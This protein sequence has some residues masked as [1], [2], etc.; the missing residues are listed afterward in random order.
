MTPKLIDYPEH[1]LLISRTDKR[2]IILAANEAF[3]RVSGFAAQDL[4]GAPHKLVR[5]TDM[6]RG[7][8]WHIWDR[9]KND[10]SASGYVKNKTA[11]GD[12]YWVLANITPLEDGYFSLRVKPEPDSLTLIEPLYHEMIQRE[13]DRRISPELS[14]AALEEQIASQGLGSYASV[15]SA[16]LAKTL[17]KRNDTRRSAT[18]AR[19]APLAE[20]SHSWKSVGKHCQSVFEAYREF[21]NIP[22]NM[23][24]QAGGLGDQGAALGVVA[25]NFAT[26]AGQINGDL[27]SF[28]E[29]VRSVSAKICESLLLV[30]LQEL[31]AEAV[32]IFGQERSATQEELG[33][34]EKQHLISSVAERDAIDDVLQQLQLF[35]NISDGVR[36]RL[37]AL[38]V[39]RVMCSIENA[40]LSSGTG[41]SVASIIEELCV[42][43]ERTEDNLRCIQDELTSISRVLGSLECLGVAA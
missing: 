3:R 11:D 26:I 40:Q 27:V 22:M 4:I 20:A 39:T 30:C 18:P 42:F 37:S 28:T 6:P 1:E 5:H 36:R 15:V 23:Q 24:I 41:G 17:Q 9:L 14:F 10:R 32:I 21:R 25:T 12:Y 2:G 7:V 19:I 35:L 43:Q 8:F 38:S 13:K 31:L 33:I 29:S 16:D 34:L